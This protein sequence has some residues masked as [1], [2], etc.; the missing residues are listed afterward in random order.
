MVMARLPTVGSDDGQWGAI[1]NDFLGTEHNPDGTLK[2]RTD[3]TLS[4][5]VRTNDDQTING[6]K[7]FA[8]SPVV[9]APTQDAHAAT[10]LYVDSVASS[11]APDATTSTKGIVQLAGDLGGTATSPTVPGLANRQPLNSNLTAIAGL[12]PAANDILQYQSGAWA[13]RTPAQLKT[14]LS[15]TK[16]DVG[17]GDVDNT[18]DLNKPVSNATQTQLD[19]KAPTT[20][21]IATGTGLTGGGNLTADRTLSVVGDS[22]TQRVEVAG[23]GTLQGT[24]KQV[25]FIG[26][27]NASVTVVDDSANNKVDVTIDATTQTAPDATTSA[28][29]IVQLAGDLGGT[30]TSPTVPGLSLKANTSTTVSAGTGLTGGGDLSANRT[31]S[32]NFGTTAG[33]ITQGNDARLSDARTPTTHASTHASGGTDP[34]TPQA[35]GAVPVT[36]SFASAPSNVLWTVNHTYSTAQVADPNIYE[37]YQGGTLVS[38]MNEWGGLRFRIPST[39]AFDA[40]IRIIAAASQNGPLMQVQNSARTE[41]WMAISQTGEVQA[42]RGLTASAAAIANDASVGGDLSVSGNLSVTGTYPGNV[43]VSDTA[44]PSPVAGTVWIDTS[45]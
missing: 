36:Q 25:N 27:T 32:A 5:F 38:W 22:T 11:G 18:T 31:I 3:G 8:S 33:T 42:N 43:I 13:N 28:K 41:D 6:T 37:M 1:L 2:I 16:A 4:A 39:S 12:S 40:A 34:V 19:G 9:P 24:R 45:P 26:G 23:D 35:I 20:R 17:L 30:A 10:K 44:P 7:T 21:T 15:L 29:G 14:S